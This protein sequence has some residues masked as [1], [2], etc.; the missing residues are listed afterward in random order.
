[1]GGT[2]NNDAD[3][4]KFANRATMS[5][6]QAARPGDVDGI[7]ATAVR[8]RGIRTRLDHRVAFRFEGV[9]VPT[10]LAAEEVKLAKSP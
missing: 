9:T 4:F 2:S 6:W 7:A 10:L 8:D 1:M 5:L 3:A